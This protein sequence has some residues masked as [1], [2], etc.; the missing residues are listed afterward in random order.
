MDKIWG[1]NKD[2]FRK[3]DKIW[4]FNKNLG[5]MTDSNKSKKDKK[6]VKWL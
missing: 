5:K 3:N 1:F 2:F 6:E 4:G